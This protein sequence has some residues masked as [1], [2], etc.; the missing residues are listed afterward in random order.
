[1]QATTDGARADRSSVT[2]DEAVGTIAGGRARGERGERGEMLAALSNA[3]VSIHKQFYGKGP[4]KAR[5]H[6]M[7][8]LVVVV[9][10]GGFTRGEHTLSDHGFQREV[11]QSRMAMQN[12]VEAEFRTA[13][14]II[15]G[16]PVRSFMSAADPANDLQ[17]EIFVLYPGGADPV[18]ANGQTGAATSTATDLSLG[19][20]GTSGS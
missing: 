11:M 1:M 12:S 15:L 9:L 17:A 16:R 14:E 10:D 13:V 8:D 19:D 2:R 3:V 7:N 4:T 6:M 18:A 5:T 20:D